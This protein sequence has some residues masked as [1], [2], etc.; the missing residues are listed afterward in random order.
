MVAEQG[1]IL[2]IALAQGAAAFERIA[3]SPMR[4]MRSKPM[5]STDFRKVPLAAI[6]CIWCV[7]SVSDQHKL[8]GP[9]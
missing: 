5:H 9:L 3:D 4:T 1:I 7:R 2:A 8:V 6:R